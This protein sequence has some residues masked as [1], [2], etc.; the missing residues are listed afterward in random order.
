MGAV[1]WIIVGMF[2]LTGAVL[3][4]MLYVGWRDRDIGDA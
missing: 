2:V 3:A 4:Y 1:E